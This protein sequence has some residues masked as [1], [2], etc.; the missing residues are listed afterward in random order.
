MDEQTSWK[1]HSFTLMVFAGIVVLCSIFFTLGMLV[2]RTQARKLA[3]AEAAE[4]ADAAAQLE[5]KPI[6]EEK[7]ELT[8][9]E[10][11]EDKQLPL[12]EPVVAPPEP[13]PPARPRAAVP[14]L[15]ANAVNFQIMALRKLTDAEKLH[16][17]L[18]RKNFRA[19]IV[20]P[21]SKDRS[22]LFRVQVGPFSEKEADLA[23][24]RLESAGYK[25][26]VRR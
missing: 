4:A 6:E 13:P 1:G 14:A 22:P 9:Y 16:A 3:A 20:A 5:L 10:S 21:S 23:R 25:P 7:P 8:F 15:P 18:K 17:E 26:I 11:V 24:R 12:E 2:G 19:F